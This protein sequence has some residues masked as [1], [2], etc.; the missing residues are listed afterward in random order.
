MAYG[1]WSHY[2]HIDE[3]VDGVD[4]TELLRAIHTATATRAT[5]RQLSTAGGDGKPWETLRPG[6]SGCI[7]GRSLAVRPLLRRRLKT[8]PE[9]PAFSTR[10]APSILADFNDGVSTP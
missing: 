7:H 9:E 6:H 3:L 10:R 4:A 8:A 2:L 5:R 1:E